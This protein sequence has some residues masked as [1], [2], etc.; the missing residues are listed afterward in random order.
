MHR[1]STIYVSAFPEEFIRPKMRNP[2][3]VY[4]TN[5]LERF[6]YD[7]WM[8]FNSSNNASHITR[9]SSLH[10]CEKYCAKKNECWGCISDCLNSCQWIAISECG[11][12]NATEELFDGDLFQKTGNCDCLSNTYLVVFC[13]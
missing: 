7:T 2:C 4:K 12:L 10:Q 13:K 3:N 9:N 1:F 5:T 8:S 11:T 6:P